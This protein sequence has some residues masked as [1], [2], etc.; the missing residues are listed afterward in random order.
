MYPLYCSMQRQR[1]LWQ[2]TIDIPVLKQMVPVVGWMVT[3]KNNVFVPENCDC[4][5]VGGG[6][7]KVFADVIKNLEIRVSWITQVGPKSNNESL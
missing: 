6:G 7:T 1:V 3:S 5:F 4:D 2:L